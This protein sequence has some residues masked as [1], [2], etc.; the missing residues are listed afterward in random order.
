MFR[1]K[2]KVW[3][4]YG[5][6]ILDGNVCKGIE[7]CWLRMATDQGVTLQ[8]ADVVYADDTVLVKVQADMDSLRGCSL[9]W[10]AGDLSRDTLEV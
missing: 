1:H 6:H 7:A 2:G 10:L 8:D 4:I 9:L 3:V 5:D